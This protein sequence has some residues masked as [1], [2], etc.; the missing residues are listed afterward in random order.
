MTIEAL[1]GQISGHNQNCHEN[2]KFTSLIAL[3]GGTT[4]LAELEN[5]Y[6]IRGAKE[7]DV[8]I[9][10]TLQDGGSVSDF[11]LQSGD[12]IFVPRT[13]WSDRGITI[14]ISGAALLV[15]IVALILRK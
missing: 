5:M 4:T 1:R 13:W 7:I 3:A 8:D 12:Q 2:E 6:I 15:T 9:E 11:G 10:T 14:V